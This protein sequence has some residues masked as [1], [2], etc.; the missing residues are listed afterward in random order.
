MDP[1]Q[2]VPFGETRHGSR[3]ESFP[4]PPSIGR[5]FERTEIKAHH[6]NRQGQSQQDTVKQAHKV[7]ELSRL[8]SGLN[9]LGTGVV[10]KL[11]LMSIYFVS[12]ASGMHWAL[13]FLL[14]VTNDFKLFN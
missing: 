1:D 11:T 12:A 13:K 2:L 14:K 10:G 8:C 5:R 6:Q 3:P 4:D 7:W 9:Q